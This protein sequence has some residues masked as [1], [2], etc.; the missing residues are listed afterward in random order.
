MKPNLELLTVPQ[1]TTDAV[2]ARVDR[3][4]WSARQPLRVLTG[5]EV[6]QASP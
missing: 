3:R 1:V 2:A 6:A 5:F 4:G